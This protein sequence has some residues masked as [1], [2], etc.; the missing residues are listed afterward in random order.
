MSGSPRSA[1]VI[2]AGVQGLTT[3]VLLAEAGRPVHVRSTDRPE[4]TTSGAGGSMWGATFM[5]PA[6]RAPAWVAH[7][8]EVFRAL[9]EEPRSGVRLLS[10]TMAARY[11]LGTGEP[12]DVRLMPDLRRCDPGEL[13]EGFTSGYRAT[14]PVVDMP[15]YLDY[16]VERLRAAGGQLSVEPVPSLGE[17]ARQAPVV[18]NCAGIGALELAD[19]PDVYPLRG[20]TVA[21]RNPGVDQYFVELTSGAEYATFF[22][23]GSRLVLGGVAISHD[24][25]RVASSGITEGILSRCAEVEPKLSEAEV[26]E[27]RVGLRPARTLVR[28]DSEKR[29]GAQVVHNY[30]HARSGISLSWGCAAEVERLITLADG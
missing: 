30:G 3:G 22:P 26:L 10:G 24:W 13:P 5:R 29:C 25:Q 8:M 1:L 28:L 4:D 27:E 14:L 17:A 9:A 6:H 7:S 21:V 2:G 18:V 20:Q 12:R 15:H 23:H 16:L 19:D 11:Q